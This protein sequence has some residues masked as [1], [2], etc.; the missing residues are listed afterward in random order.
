MNLPSY[1]PRCRLTRAERSR[2]R[3]YSVAPDGRH[4]IVTAPS[5]AGT[6]DEGAGVAPAR[7]AQCARRERP[8]AGAPP[9]GCRTRRA[10][11][12]RSAGKTRQGRQ[13]RR[14]RAAT[15]G[16]STARWRRRASRPHARAL[17]R[18]RCRGRLLE[19]RD[20]DG[21]ERGRHFL[22]SFARV[23]RFGFV[24]FSSRGISTLASAR[25]RSRSSSRR[26]SS[27]VGRYVRY[28][29]AKSCLYS[30]RTE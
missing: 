3:V 16:A 12:R 7:R 17:G 21:R 1:A 18:S 23:A 20:E 30:F 6:R 10:R 2:T 29:A 24:G 27:S 28:F 14:T 25:R 13:R 5:R 9:L 26:S 22:R 15:R 19:A 11:G 4:R 8:S